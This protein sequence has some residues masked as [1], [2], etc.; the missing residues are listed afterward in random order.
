MYVIL[1]IPN[2][3]TPREAIPV[4]ALP[5]V[6]P[7]VL[8]AERLA[9]DFSRS[10]DHPE[11]GVL[12]SLY[13]YCL[14][15]DGKALAVP[16]NQWDRSLT[17]ILSLSIQ[18]DLEGVQRE[19]DER[20]YPIDNHYR[21][22]KYDCDVIMCLPH[23]V[24]VWKDELEDAY[25]QGV[26]QWEAYRAGDLE[27]YY[28]PP[29][30]FEL[31]AVVME[32]F[33]GGR[34]D[35]VEFAETMSFPVA[36]AHLR[37]RLRANDF[38]IREWILEG[39]IQAYRHSSR[40]LDHRCCKAEPWRGTPDP[41]GDG[42]ELDSDGRPKI[43]HKR[44][45]LKKEVEQFNPA[46]PSDYEMAPESYAGF[47]YAGDHGYNPSGRFV[48]FS[49]AVEFVRPFASDNDIEKDL[50]C[51]IDDG[52]IPAHGLTPK[53]LSLEDSFFDDGLTPEPLSLEDS[54]FM[55][56][57]IVGWA[58][59]KFA[60]PF[61]GWDAITRQRPPFSVSE[62]CSGPETVTLTAATA[63]PPAGPNVGGLGPDRPRDTVRP[64]IPVTQP[65]RFKD[66]WTPAIV[67]AIS[68]FERAHRYTANE[69]QLWQQLRNNPPDGYH[70]HWDDER[71]KRLCMPDNPPLD[72]AKFSE[73]FRRLYPDDKPS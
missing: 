4:R 1:E 54:F 44:R 34:T 56:S 3:E 64:L 69:A 9:K 20:G 6:A 67:D 70:I 29:I 33:A 13:T 46:L 40:R 32:G 18:L 42:P 28:Y 8:N 37:D 48:S 58:T 31:E 60:R 43:Y 25:R 65:Q 14:T 24:F 51:E 41:D 73:R 22:N 38:E 71:A 30:P 23:G 59:T 35:C 10:A 27:P 2:G 15:A 63:P 21:D 16:P 12:R 11:F 49:Q 62:E 52:G 57:Q 45:F 72:R 55:E 61:G 26:S 7:R 47:H 50:G 36:R 66:D 17:A 19:Y 5:F 68:A 39:R 53:P